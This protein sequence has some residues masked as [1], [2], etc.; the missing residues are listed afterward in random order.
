[1]Y[2]PRAPL[3]WG[4][5]F[6]GV[7]I[8]GCAARPFVDS[9]RLAQDLA[10]AGGLTESRVKAGGFDVRVYHKG[11][12]RRAGC[13]HVYLEGDGNAWPTP[14]R[15]ST[16]PTPLNP[17][18]LKLAARDPGASVLYVA[19]PCQFAESTALARCNPEF[20]TSRR[21]SPEVVAAVD[22][23]LDWAQ[24]GPGHE[25]RIG[26]VGYS[27]GGTVATLVA[28]GR[29][30]VAWL[31]TVAGNLDPGAWA[32][33]HRVTPLRG[34]LTPLDVA[35]GLRSVPQL[36]LQGAN[37]SEVPPALATGYLKHFQG[38]AGIRAEVI[39]DFDHACCWQDRW[40]EL[41]CRWQPFSGCP[42]RTPMAEPSP[43]HPQQQGR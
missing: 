38:V 34:S 6:F 41:L 27:G 18:A 8:G 21:Y 16:D 28:A 9:R 43:S 22:R 36:H 33:W 31:V 39:P 42:G 19:R 26:L 7:L 40:P 13:L 24:A 17:M 11:L 25:R 23:V 4:L 35:D 37:D 30:D 10:R 3:W 2:L 29:R 20:W 5:V 1:M 32:A 12:Q 15:R 14:Y